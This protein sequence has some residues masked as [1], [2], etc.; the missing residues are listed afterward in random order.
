MVQVRLRKG[1]AEFM[2]R[3]FPHGGLEV[4]CL[5]EHNADLS[6]RGCISQVPGIYLQDVMDNNGQYSNSVRKRLRD[7]NNGRLPDQKCGYCYARRHN[8]GKVT[9]SEVGDKTRQ[10]FEDKK[11]KFVRIS[12]NNEAGHIFYRPALINFLELCKEFRT[13]A[14][15]PQ[16]MLE[17]DQKVAD[18][19]R[20]TDSSLMYSI[21]WDRCEQ[22]A[23]SQGFTNAWRI[24]QAKE[25]ALEGVNTSLTIVCDITSSI[26][27]NVSRGSSIRKALDCDLGIVKTRILPLR[28]NSKI[29]ARKLLGIEWDDAKYNPP[30]PDDGN[31]NLFP[32]EY[33][34][35]LEREADKA[36]Y[37]I[38][39][40]GDL[41]A[42]FFHKDFFSFQNSIS[43][44]G[45]VGPNEYCDK[46]NLEVARTVFPASQL[47]KVVY[48]KEKSVSR[49]NYR[50]KKAKQKRRGQMELF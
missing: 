26:D 50:A 10:D 3:S 30:I 17:Y 35:E 31:P 23:C 36:R 27:E 21:G 42:R 40:G 13:R 16:K 15:F 9:S 47:V 48:P 44:C 19:L 39:D 6:V 49:Q 7:E 18:L 5:C 32:E 33:I 29:I 2:T 8:Y 11:P 25:Y 37:F 20:E 22:G 43:V 24:E 12:K 1:K 41:I 46:C 45:R 4:V 38:N 28:P 14:I 34:Q